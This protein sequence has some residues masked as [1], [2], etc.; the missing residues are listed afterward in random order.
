MSSLTTVVTELFFLCIPGAI[1]Q[2]MAPLSAGQAHLQK[3][4]QPTKID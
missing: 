3:Q 4:P 1:L 2:S